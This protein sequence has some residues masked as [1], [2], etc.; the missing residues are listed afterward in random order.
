MM[1]NFRSVQYVNNSDENPSIPLRPGPHLYSETVKNIS[2]DNSPSCTMIITDSM[3]G[4]IKMSNIKSNIVVRDREFIIKRFP[5][6][7]A[8]EMACYAPKPLSDKKPDQV[9]LV[10]GTNDLTRSM[11][12]SGNVDEYEVVNS[13]LM[14]GRAARNYG[15]Q[16]IHISG[17]MARRGYKYG[18]A[19]RRVNDLLHMACVAE[20]FLYM[21]QDDI[22]S[23][24]LSAD[25]V[26][27]N[28]YGTAVLMFNIFSVFDSFNCDLMDF[29]DDYNY[30]LLLG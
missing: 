19:V 30:A 4:G 8:E 16:K 27:L 10:A 12:D 2:R 3:A 5:G 23:V 21:C 18:E 25:G 28:S 17:I 14:I 15:A 24:H 22:K 20:D 13:I 6:H 11:Y 1:N 29:K 7:T 9:I 26:H